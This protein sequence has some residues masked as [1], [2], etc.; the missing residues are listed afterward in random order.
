MSRGKLQ[1]WDAVVDFSVTNADTTH[2][3]PVGASLATEMV[4]M[5][6]ADETNSEFE[7]GYGAPGQAGPNY[8]AQRNFRT[9][10]GDSDYDSKWGRN[11]QVFI[12]LIQGTGGVT[13]LTSGRVVFNGYI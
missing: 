3:I 1:V 12:R 11:M 5:K 10:P 2:W 6:I 4:K 9:I 7:I 13:T 8:V